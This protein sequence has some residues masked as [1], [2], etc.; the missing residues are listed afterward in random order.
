[1]RE[2]LLFGERDV[3]IN[4]NGA[5]YANQMRSCS[6]SFQ[7]ILMAGF[8]GS[9]MALGMS[10]HLEVEEDKRASWYIRQD[11]S[12]RQRLQSESDAIV[13]V[14]HT[15][16]RSIDL[17]TS[18]APDAIE[19]YNF[20]ANVD[21]KIRKKDLGESPFENIPQILTYLID[22]Y[23]TLTPDLA[24]MGILKLHAI[25]FQ[26]WNSLINSGLKVTGLGGTDS[27]E[28]VFKEKGSDG[29]R[30]DSH[31]RITRL[32]SNHFLVSSIDPDVI[33]D[34]LKK[35]RGWLVFEGLGSP[36]DMDF[37]ADGGGGSIGVGETG[38][39]Q[40]G[41]T[42]L[43]VKVPSLSPASP[44]GKDQPHLRVELR[45]IQSDGS[46]V[47]VVTS[48]GDDINYSVT[49]PGVYRAQVWITPL[50]LK[51]YLGAFS[52]YSGQEYPWIITNPI[53]LNP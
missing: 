28:N 32:M 5:I 51:S 20:H 26:K 13:V 17:M 7:P 45:Q 35:G 46:D 4:K 8:E 27:H 50:H 38:Q 3:E 30:L 1:M 16:S 47:A 36:K 9:L 14:P 37:Y 10:Q 34:A 43:H 49:S 18:I 40:A 44:Q 22:P 21:P 52:K 53:Y 42:I 48:G 6:N 2:L 31:R 23:A 15:E 11:S 33:K 24:F 12:L 25:Y 41:K 39:F 29:E 19:I